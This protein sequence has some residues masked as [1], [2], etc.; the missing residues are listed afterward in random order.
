M[1]VFSPKTLP[2]PTTRLKGIRQ[3]KQATDGKSE[4]KEGTAYGRS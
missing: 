2:L 4:E 1:S 3:R